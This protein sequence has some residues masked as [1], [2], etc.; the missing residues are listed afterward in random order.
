MRLRPEFFV[1]VLLCTSVTA[2]AE[3]SLQVQ[4][5]HLP[6][7]ADFSE[8]AVTLT[9]DDVLPSDYERHEQEEDE[10]E[11]LHLTLPDSDAAE[12]PLYR[13]ADLQG[14]SGYHRQYW[15]EPVEREHSTNAS[16]NFKVVWRF[17]L[18]ARDDHKL[19]TLLKGTP[20]ALRLALSYHH[21]EDEHARYGEALLDLTHTFTRIDGVP[22]EAPQQLQLMPRHRR[23]HVSWN[24]AEEITY[25]NEQGAF[26]AAVVL[27][28]VAA[29][30][31]EPLD[32]SAAAMLFRP[33]A[34]GG[35]VP[36]SEEACV[37]LPDCK[38]DCAADKD[39]YF[40]LDKLQTVA[41]MQKSKFMHGGEGVISDLNAGNTYQVMLQYFPDG[42]KRS[43][44]RSAVVVEN[45]TL[46]EL[47]GADD[48]TREDL[49]CFIATAAWGSS[50]AVVELRWLRDRLLMPSR[51]GRALVAFYY[52]HAPPLAALVAD[53]VLLRT[54]VRIVLL[55]PLLLVLFLKSPSLLAVIVAVS[56]FWMWWRRL[57]IPRS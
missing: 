36:L 48:A 28:I 37:L 29:K 46:F 10:W 13:E 56:V 26:P 55:A 42:V 47:N 17:I 41:G 2:F 57:V 14:V 40:D 44:C 51:W 35:D 25:T 3:L 43:E 23:L 38:L 6:R 27:A 15:Y 4:E 52:R 31:S 1:S 21:W 45:R 30:S 12:L 11:R 9:I 53:N 32:L 18:K 24:V 39:V 5:V 54:L 33:A 50:R 8:L 20:P 34:D 16:G 49:R 22:A 19:T 7:S